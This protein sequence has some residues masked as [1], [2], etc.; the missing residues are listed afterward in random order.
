ME[1]KE[2]FSKLTQH[3]IEG[4]MT[5][6]HL[7]NYYDFLGLPG[8]KE[9]HE[10]HFMEETCSYRKLC[11]YFTEHYNMLIPEGV[12][13]TPKVI[14]ESW[15]NHVRQDVDI[16]TKRSAVKAGLEKWK[17][18]E[19]DTHRFYKEMYEE[20]ESLND[21]SACHMV[22]ELICDVEHELINIHQYLLNKEATDYNMSSII[23][24]QKMKH[25]KY[26]KKLDGYT[27]NKKHH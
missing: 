22:A 10:Y 7:A 19:T 14:P 1:V 9:C 3:M 27:G 15:Y 11:H 2:I 20:L 13:N 26:R 16:N 8:Y 6:E 21:V 4:M 25:H 24:E 18:W 5:H 23:N 17:D 12:I